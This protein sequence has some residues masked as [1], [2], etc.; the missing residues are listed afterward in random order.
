MIIFL[1]RILCDA[2]QTPSMKTKTAQL[3]F[4]EDLA[5]TYCTATEFSTQSP[6]DKAI[7]KIIQMSMDQKSKD[8]RQQAQFC[9]IALYNCNTPN[10]SILLLGFLMLNLFVLN[11]FQ[12]TMLLTNLPKNYQDSAKSIIQQHLRRSNSG[13]FFFSFY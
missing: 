7:L 9:L 8:L 2:T 13:M 5:K 3:K 4:L 1:F 6:A 12:M 10:V 11:I